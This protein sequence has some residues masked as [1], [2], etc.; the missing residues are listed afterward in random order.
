M[1]RL[2][3]CLGTE[4]ADIGDFLLIVDEPGVPIHDTTP[5][6]A[7]TSEENS[8]EVAGNGKALKLPLFALDSETF[9]AIGAMM[10]NPRLRARQ[11]ALLTFPVENR[12]WC[13][14]SQTR[15]P[16]LYHGFARFDVDQRI[17]AQNHHPVHVD[18]GRLWLHL[19][20]ARLHDLFALPV[21]YR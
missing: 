19:G 8:V 7:L 10:R 11:V 14:R 17:P 5:N 20:I 9:G 21:G 2:P 6:V 3:K 12:R 15:K 13:V 18:F 1:K 4:V 16:V